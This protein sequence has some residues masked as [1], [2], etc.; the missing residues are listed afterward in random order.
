MKKIKELLIKNEI[1]FTEYSNGSIRV[2]TFRDDL[3]I[4]EYIRLFFN[5]SEIILSEK[6]KVIA[7]KDVVNS[8]LIIDKK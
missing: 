3:K 7:E 6:L 2:Y 8:V 4:I 5:F 1:Q